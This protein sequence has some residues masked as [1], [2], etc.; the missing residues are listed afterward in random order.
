M[1]LQIVKDYERL[2]RDNEDL[3][4]YNQLYE[5]RIETLEKKYQTLA[6]EFLKEK[7]KDEKGNK[8]N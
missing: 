1:K 6:N 3:R 2:L 5:Q 8:R 7:K 4:Y